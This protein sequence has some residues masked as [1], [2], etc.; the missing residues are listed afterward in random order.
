MGEYYFETKDLAVGYDGTVVAD[1]I[2][3]GLRKC[4]ILALI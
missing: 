2:N 3:F 1:K 4:E